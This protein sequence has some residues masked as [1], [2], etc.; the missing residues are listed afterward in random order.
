MPIITQFTTEKQIDKIKAQACVPGKGGVERARQDFPPFKCLKKKVSDGKGGTKPNPKL[1]IEGYR[2]G[3]N[4][5]VGNCP[6]GK[7]YSTYSH[8]CVKPET[9]KKH[10]AV[11][12]QHGG[13]YH[14][15]AYVNANGRRVARKENA[16]RNSDDKPKRALVPIT[17]LARR[18]NPDC[19]PTDVYEKN[20]VTGRCLK[21]CE[22]GKVRSTLTGRCTKNLTI[23]NFRK[24]DFGK[25]SYYTTADGKRATKKDL[26]G[27]KSLLVK[28]TVGRTATM[29]N[30]P[31]AIRHQLGPEICRHYIG[32]GKGYTETPVDSHEYNFAL[33]RCVAK[34][35]AQAT[36]FQRFP[37]HLTH[38]LGTQTAIEAA[39]TSDLHQ[40]AQGQMS[41]TSLKEAVASGHR[42]KASKRPRSSSPR[43]S[44]RSSISTPLDVEKAGPSTLATSS[45]R[46]STRSKK[47][48]KYT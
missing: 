13:V 3:Y 23:N 38:L 2:S 21:R 26:Q 34:G 7:A 44:P 18:K 28:K 46:R 30:I 27:N 20:P 22:P 10:E 31:K 29:S 17:P 36:E 24:A 48:V 37:A 42:S 33:G 9:L 32:R 11:A 25:T 40:V 12:A 4:V 43:S 16:A 19:L 35:K 8:R 47:A 6:P 41:G 45:L 1:K 5:L 15:R 39:A 14:V